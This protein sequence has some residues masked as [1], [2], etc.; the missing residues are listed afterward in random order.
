MKEMV[1]DEQT[2]MRDLI[3]IIWCHNLI[4]ETGRPKFVYMYGNSHKSKI[5]LIRFT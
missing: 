1:A 4:T 2:T 5:I 3:F